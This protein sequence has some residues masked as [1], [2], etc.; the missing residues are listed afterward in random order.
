MSP[1]QKLF[2][3][4][5]YKFFHIFGCACFPNLRPYN[6]HR[7]EFRFK[8]CVF[9]GYSPNHKGY[10]C[11]QIESRKIYVYRD[12]VFHETIFPSSNPQNLAPTPLSTSSHALIPVSLPLSPPIHHDP[13]LPHTKTHSETPLSPTPHIGSNLSDATLVPPASTQIHTMATRAQ[14]NIRC[15]C[16]FTDGTVRYPVPR[17]LLTIQASALQ[18]PTC[19]TTA[20]NV[21]EWLQAMQNEFNALA[22]KNWTP[23]PPS[24]AANVVGYKWVFKLKHKADGT[25]EHH[26]AS[27]VAKGFHQ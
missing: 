27:L 18:Q 20:V 1:Y 9:M 21:P 22:N 2:K 5:H 16:H 19:Y 3:T 24:T 26:K 13:G 12:V 8:E 15:P 25:V 7:F 4:S 17:A 10:R 11:L 6:N 23:V 14:H